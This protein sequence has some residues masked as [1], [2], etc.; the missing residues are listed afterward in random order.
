MKFTQDRSALRLIID[1]PCALYRD[2]LLSTGLPVRSVQEDMQR[3]QLRRQAGPARA[4]CD[5]T[6]AAEHPHEV[7]VLLSAVL[8]GASLFPLGH[9]KRRPSES[10]YTPSER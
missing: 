2:A 5:R 3:P 10:K 9:S 1:V 7:G 4:Q 6:C 8:D